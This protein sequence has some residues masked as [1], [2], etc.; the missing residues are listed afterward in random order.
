MVNVPEVVFWHDVGRSGRNG[1][2]RHDAT[3]ITVIRGVEVPGMGLWYLSRC[4]QRLFS[5]GAL[6]SVKMNPCKDL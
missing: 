6:P 5:N 4:F 1:H 3:V 2:D